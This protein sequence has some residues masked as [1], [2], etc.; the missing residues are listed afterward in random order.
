MCSGQSAA[1][2]MTTSPDITLLLD[3]SRPDRS[4]LVTLGPALHYP[5]QHYGA[6]RTKPAG[7]PKGPDTN[8]PQTYF[9][10]VTMLTEAHSYQPTSRRSG[11]PT[12]LP[13]GK[14]TPQQSYDTWNDRSD[15]YKY[16]ITK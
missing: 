16:M 15:I 6:I 4:H 8:Q 2:V 1:N 14:P 3:N 13:A 7:D 9:A 10:K 12:P 11:P 5:L